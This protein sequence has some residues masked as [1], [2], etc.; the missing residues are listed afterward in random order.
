M[1]D[2]HANTKT[3]SRI[4]WFVDNVGADGVHIDIRRHLGP[5]A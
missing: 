1:S 4:T 2:A 5:L 3:M